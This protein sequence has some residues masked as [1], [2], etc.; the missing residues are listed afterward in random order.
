MS[1][2][3]T[4]SAVDVPFLAGGAKKLL[5]GG[6]WVGAASGKTM[7]SINPSTGAVLVDVADGD[8]DDVER[9]V[10]AARTAFEGPWRTTSPAARQRL[11]WKIA[12]VLEANYAEL[13]TLTAADMGTPV[14][15]DP[16]LGAEYVM[17]MVRYFA[18]WPTKI[19]G[20]TL[21]NSIPGMLTYTRK[22]PIG[23]VAAYVPYNSPLTQFVKKLGAVLATNCTMV[24]KPADQASL[25][26]LRVAE[27]C[28]E[29]GVPEG[30]INV[31]TGGPAAGA[32]IAE[33]PGVDSI[34]F[35]GSTTVGQELVRAA[36]GNLKRLTL[37]L[38]GKSPHIIF[39]DADLAAAVPMAAMMVF[40]NSGQGCSNG[41]R[42]FVERAVYDD[43][44]QGCAQ[45]AGT[46]KAGNSLDPETSLGPVITAQHLARVMGYVESGQH[47]G[48]RLVAGGNRIEDGEL[49]N[50]YFVAPTVFADVHDTMRIAREEIFGP[51]ACIL[52]FDSLEEVVGRANAT[53][54]GLAGGVWTRDIGKA[55]RVADALHAGTVW[56]N[57]YNQL[58]PAVPFGGYQMSGWGKEAGPE[59]LEGFLNTKSVWINT[60]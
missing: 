55:H 13:K 22:E 38:G 43:V 36:A 40:A 9:A 52:P 44:V 5:I 24:V 53:S 42:I 3:T 21:A 18:G 30:V 31:V 47:E 10:A 25:T 17:D 20:D 46:L 35:T 58:D 48:A 57:T 11:L 32:A 39:A 37:E 54:F 41:T 27:L 15:R 59:S 1:S 49:A 14:G 51:V 33:H 23:V 34:V 16:R 26:I 28:L 12:D 19:R 6:D 60:Q 2:V 7:P 45:M 50:G 8:A 29:A 4:P 56:V